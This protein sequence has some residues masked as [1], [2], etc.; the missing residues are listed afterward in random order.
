MGRRF[1]VGLAREL[2]LRELLIGRAVSE[3]SVLCE[4]IGV[5]RPVGFFERYCTLR[6]R[7]TVPTRFR[8]LKW[9]GVAE[10]RS[11]EQNTG[12]HVSVC[13]VG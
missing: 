11:D 1:A 9:S 3:Q 4:L 8:N 5:D 10:S 12:Q 13:G 6:V 2:A 7:G